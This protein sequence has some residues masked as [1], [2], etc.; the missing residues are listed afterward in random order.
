MIN[1]SEIY[2]PIKELRHVKSIK[3]TGATE[4]QQ[5]HVT[6]RVKR[7]WKKENEGK[8]GF[9]SEKFNNVNNN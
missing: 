1:R 7:K 6:D 4:T 9:K 5:N 8:N 3:W 2:K